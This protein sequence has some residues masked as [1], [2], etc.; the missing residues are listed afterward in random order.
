MPIFIKL[1]Q[2]KIHHCTYGIWQHSYFLNFLSNYVFTAKQYLPG[3]KKRLLCLSILFRWTTEYCC[4][5]LLIQM[6]MQFE[7]L[8]KVINSI[9]NRHIAEL[10]QRGV[11]KYIILLCMISQCMLSEIII[12]EK[13]ACKTTNCKEL[14]DLKAFRRCVYLVF[15]VLYALK[16]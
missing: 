16:I 13:C 3:K 15:T 5:A 8:L 12:K 11:N 7:F 10:Y 1:S 6:Q 2:G 4:F 9:K 14:S